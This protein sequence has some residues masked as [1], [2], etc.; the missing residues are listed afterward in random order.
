ML[1]IFRTKKYR[2]IAAFIIDAP[3]E[4]N[5]VS[6]WCGSQSNCGKCQQES[7]VAVDGE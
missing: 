6:G 1:N 3:V 7:F 5:P 4:N 2:Q